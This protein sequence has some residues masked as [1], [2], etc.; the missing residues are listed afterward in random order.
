M[1]LQFSDPTA[2][3]GIVE[4]L[5]DLTDTQSATSSSYSLYKKTR[6][7]NIALA[8]FFILGQ[9]ESGRWQLD[10]NNHTDYPIIFGDIVN[11]QQDYSM[12]TDEHGNQIL[13]VYKVRVKA[14]DGVNWITLDQRDVHSKDGNDEPLNS[15]AEGTPQEYDLNANGIF[16]FPTPNYDMEDGLEVYID[17]TAN[18]FVY[19]DTTKTA[20]IPHVFHEY[21][22][23]R[24][25]YFYCT[26][27]GLPQAAEYKRA[28]YGDDGKGGMERAIKNYFGG[29]NKDEQITLTERPTIN[30]I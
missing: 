26:Q 9:M 11:H 1:L 19:T 23:M 22:A 17:R 28:L 7:I 25:A 6:D 30:H 27:K 20:G 4:L 5:G 21:L 8:W 12:L 16:L 3:L 14:P 2:K 10:D 13:G 24:P 18:Y 15:V 29:R